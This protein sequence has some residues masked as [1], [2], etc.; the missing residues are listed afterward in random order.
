MPRPT[1]HSETTVPFTVLVL[2]PSI[3]PGIG[4][5]DTLL[6]ELEESRISV[7]VNS[8]VRTIG[9]DNVVIRT[10]DGEQR[11]DCDVFVGDAFGVAKIIDAVQSVYAIGKMI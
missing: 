10:G 5:G 8:T 9:E 7:H 1:I 4:F 6:R 3:I 11:I 2:V